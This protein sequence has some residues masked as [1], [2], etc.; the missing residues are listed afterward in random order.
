[1]DN[2]VSEEQKTKLANR[3]SNL[4]ESF[5]REILKVTTRPDIISFAG[6]LPNPD[7][8]PVEKLQ[9]VTEEVY[10]EEGKEA[11]QYTVTEGYQPLREKIAERYKADGLHVSP[12]NILI[13]NGSMQ[14]LDLACKLLI[15]PGDGI[16]VSRPTFIGAL[17]SFSIYEPEYSTAD[18]YHDGPDTSQIDQILDQKTIKLFYCVPNFQ[19]PTG[20]TFS[21]TKRN[22]IAQ[23]IEKTQTIILEDDPYGE[24]KFT[25]KKLPR[26]KKLLP[27][28]TILLGS[29][30]KIV[31]PGLRTGWVVAP[32]H[33]IRKLVILKQAADTHNNNL[34]QRILYRFL[35]E[36]DAT[37]HISGIC[38]AYKAQRDLMAEQIKV[39]FPS[40]VKVSVPDGG[41]FLWAELPNTI[42]AYEVFEE[43]I[44]EKVAFVPGKTFYPA[45]DVNNTFRLNFSNSNE[46]KIKVGIER[47]GKAIKK[48]L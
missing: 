40:E 7:L 23:L 36:F 34:T 35:E 6:G 38:S 26:F 10:R 48:I 32:P 41:M 13:T 39:H 1:M 3:V 21:E 2:K 27:D 24:I 18:M 45:L 42:D 30:S 16:M 15:D 20:A 11:L 12:E 44:K 5:I 25:E 47:L 28:Q 37:D 22:E 19:N 4:P 29:F 33:L 46:E 9:K 8:F 43:A 31:A 14:G 17:Q